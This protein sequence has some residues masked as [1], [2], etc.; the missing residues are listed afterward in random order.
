MKPNIGTVY[1]V[2]AGPGDPGLLTLKG[3]AVLRD[4]EAVVYDALVNPAL[5]DL[6]PHAEKIYAGKKNDVQECRG[7]WRY[8][9]AHVDQNQIN[10]RLVKLARG[11]K[12]V[13]RLKGGDPFIFGRGGEEASY[14]GRHKIP[15]EVVPGIT[16]G[17][18]VPAYAGIPVTDRRFASTV[19]F[20]TGHED[21]RK[22]ESSVEWND[23]AGIEGT[24]VS[25]MSVQN[26]SR[27]AQ[28]LIRGGKR[29]ETPVCVIEWGTLPEQRVVE[30]TLKT[31]AR[32]V[33]RRKVK[34]PALTV[35]GEVNRLR[36][37]LSWFEK[38]PL[39]GKTVV[40]TRPRSQ[41]ASLKQALEIQGARVLEF[42][43]IRIVPPRN[44]RP[45]DEALGSFAKFDWIIFTSVNAVDSVMSRLE[46]FGKDV[47]IFYPVKLAAIGA[48][49]AGQIRKYGL[50][51]DL[52]SET[53]TSQALVETFKEQNLIAGRRFLLPRADRASDVLPRGLEAGGGKV[54][55]VIA[56]HTTGSAAPKD[57]KRIRE[58]FSQKRID[59]VTFTS[60]STVEHFFEVLPAELCSRVKSRCRFV[61]IGPV[62]T[63]TLQNFGI[64]PYREARVHTVEGLV[65]VLINE[66]RR[67]FIGPPPKRTP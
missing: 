3:R 36:K 13:V 24:L 19:V 41:A 43:A 58:I 27:V 51:P 1:L 10:R 59:Y 42:P 35:I 50:R 28:A 46:V 8:A 6:A 54:T 4:S 18:A 20:V 49:T 64:K 66:R 56:Y 65:E 34:P 63:E 57:V 44:V 23:L 55:Q 40:I 7:V 62:T 67:N 17:Y 5:L 22:K 11:G 32:E 31:I 9:P 25:F 47:R 38:K 39:K 26:L 61:S 21:P 14:L 53:Y 33:K 12:K 45:L 37:E 30:G 29:P 15:F 52:V 16:A 60:A 48:V 2:G